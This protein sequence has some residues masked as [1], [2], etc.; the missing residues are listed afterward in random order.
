[1]FRNAKRILG[2][3][4]LALFL[5]GCLANGS[6]EAAG[7]PRIGVVDVERVMLT[8]RAA[9][10]GRAHFA[11]ARERLEKGWVDLR[12][13]VKSEPEAQRN[14]TLAAGLQKLREQVARE[15]AAVNQAVH[16]VLLR[17]ARLWRQANGGA[18]VIAR[19][20][21][22]DAGPEIDITDAVIAAMDAGPDPVFPPLPEVT[23]TP[24]ARTG[25]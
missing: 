25:P 17:E 5:G 9:S 3:G 13:A 8:S 16:E 11:Q 15:E 21:L 1:M 20:N 7:V 2:A 19:Q 6:G 18:V 23:V 24:A 12:E 22:L 4:V 10:A 14:D